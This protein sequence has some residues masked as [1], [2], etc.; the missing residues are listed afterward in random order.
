M[1]MFD[2]VAVVTDARSLEQ[3]HALRGWLESLRVRVHFYRLTQTRQVLDF[4]AN[5]AAEHAWTVL[6]THGTGQAIQFRVAHQEHDD[7]DAVE[8]WEE[9]NVDLT[10]AF[11]ASTVKGSGVLLSLACGGGTQE[12]A[13]AFLD[14]G[15]DAYV[16]METPYADMDSSLLFM[17]GVFYFLLAEDR[18]FAP[19]GHDLAASVAAARRFDD[20]RCGT[21]TFRLYSRPGDG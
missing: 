2:E 14:A 10:P 15:Y 7:W 20:W 11:V 16:G 17:M 6:V 21:S 8:G 12:L 19:T 1:K 13:D 5:R 18:D 4:F 9:R 3:A